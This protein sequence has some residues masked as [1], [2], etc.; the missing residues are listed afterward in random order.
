MRFAGFLL[1]GICAVLLVAGGGW[2]VVWFSGALPAQG[3]AAPGPKSA[4]LQFVSDPP[5]TSATTSLGATCRTPCSLEIATDSSFA[6]TFARDGANPVTLPVE[7]GAEPKFR[8][9]PVFA[10]L[11]PI[12][13]PEPPPPSVGWASGPGVPVRPERIMAPPRRDRELGRRERELDKYIYGI[14]RGC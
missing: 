7:V 4:R 5:G 9:N 8:P 10:Y 2:L 6:V 11:P 14:C 13:G 3:L 1:L 12:N